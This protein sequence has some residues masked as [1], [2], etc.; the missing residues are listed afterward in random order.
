MLGRD[1][2]GKKP[3]Y[4]TQFGSHLYFASEIKSLLRVQAVWNSRKV[5][6]EAVWHWCADGRR[7]LENSTFFD[8]IHSL[9]AAC[10]TVVDQNFPNN[11]QTFWEVPCERLRE[12]D[13]SFPEA[14]RQ[15]RETLDC[16]VRIRLR[17]DVPR[18]R[19]GTGASH[20]SH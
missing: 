10:W 15:E 17:A 2:L 16:A 4:W 5:N 14:M 1:R 11:I 7:D 9:P 3:L 19:E 18:A 13:I 6:E 12:A 20:S 8:G